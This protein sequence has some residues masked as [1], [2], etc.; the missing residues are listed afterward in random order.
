MKHTLL[1]RLTN[2]VLPPGLGGEGNEG[3]QGST[4]IGNLMSSLI[5]VILIFSFIL[6]F[7]MLL[8]GGIQWLT[9]GGD[10]TGLES[11]RNKITHAIMG[12]IIVSAAY[13]VF[14]LVGNFLGINSGNGTIRL[15]FPEIG[16]P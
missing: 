6:A 7:G 3:L 12:L 13:A 15:P 8:I 14:I 4:V 1:A 9:S 5:S 10:K 11:A 16:S 2:P